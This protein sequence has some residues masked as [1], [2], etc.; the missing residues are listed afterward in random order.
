MRFVFIANLFIF[1]SAHAFDTTYFD[2][3]VLFRISTSNRDVL[4]NLLGASDK[5]E[6]IPIVTADQEKYFCMIPE[7][8]TKKKDPIVDYVG[9][10][11]GELLSTIYND[12]FC[13][14]RIESYWRYELCHGKYLRQ[15]HDDKDAKIIAE[16][17]LGSY[18]KDKNEATP[19]FDATKPP[20]KDF[21]GKLLP[22]FPVNFIHGT[23]CDV[24]G[25]PRR[26]TILYI[27]SPDQTRSFQSITE[28]KSCVYEA[29]V[30]VKELCAHPSFQK[31]EPV[32][33]EIQCF[34]S[35]K[36]DNPTPKSMLRFQNELKAKPLLPLKSNQGPL[37]QR[38]PSQ[39]VKQEVYDLFTNTDTL[40]Q[41]K[42]LKNLINTARKP[43]PSV[44]DE[45]KE[46]WSGSACLYGGTGYWRYEFCYN[47]QVSQYHEE[48][49]GK[50]T[51]INLGFY[52]PKMHKEWVVDTGE[53]VRKMLNGR[54]IQTSTMY[55][56]GDLCSEAN[57]L[58]KCEVQMKCPDK[59]DNPT[60]ISMF[61]VEPS[62]CSYILLVESRM[63]CDKIQ[64]ADEFGMLPITR[65][66][67]QAE[68][69]DD[70][71]EGKIKL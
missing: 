22:Y 5:Q 15:Y 18:P 21:D 65:S 37:T 53:E 33:H 62:T 31:E 14:L 58:R 11:P 17:Y 27:C 10:T 63:F 56:R 42:E 49:D 26:T 36:V 8:E 4:N 43:K 46:F 32:E 47:R 67:G 57:T 20:V 64:L 38:V 24:T 66:G 28:V 34:A 55:T 45:L 1:V 69:F 39:F 50:V 19:D 16:Y 35:E 68:E 30:T 44:H 40:K 51:K 9:P 52:D 41:I 13:S 7:V 25:E 70:E 3:S 71:L 48:S 6:L 2:D 12:K 59:K 54:I 61:L 23:H 60:L 29:V